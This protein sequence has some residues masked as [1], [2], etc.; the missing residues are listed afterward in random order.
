MI[1]IVD[2]AVTCKAV[3]KKGVIHVG[4]Y[5]IQAVCLLLL[6]MSMLHSLCHI[7]HLFLEYV[8]CLSLEFYCFGFMAVQLDFAHC[9][10]NTFTLGLNGYSDLQETVSVIYFQTMG[11]V[12][13]EWTY[14]MTVFVRVCVRACPSHLSAS[15]VDTSCGNTSPDLIS[16]WPLLIPVACVTFIKI[17][18]YLY[19]H[20]HSHVVAS[21]HKRQLFVEYASNGNTDLHTYL[22]TQSHVML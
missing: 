15:E 16:K 1:Y 7:P 10:I 22:F 5:C 11:R 17:C 18:K 19:E 21:I 6:V 2:L 8:K 20:D 9:L 14:R 3:L 4:A 12:H 13:L